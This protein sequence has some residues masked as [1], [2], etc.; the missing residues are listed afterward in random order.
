MKEKPAAHVVCTLAEGGYFNG[1]AALT[2]SLV[3]AGFKGNIVVGY[4]GGKP[5]WTRSLRVKDHASHVYE[6]ASGVDLRFVELA[7][8]WHLNNLK[9]HLI[10]RIFETHSDVDLIYYLDT[11]IVLKHAWETLVEWAREGVVLVLDIADSNMSPHHVYRRAWQKLSARRSLKCREVAGYVNGGCVGVN[12]AFAE[13][14][15][16]WWML[17]EELEHLGADM[18]KMKDLAGRLEFTRMDQDV[19]NATVMATETPIAL[20]GFEAMGLFPYS[21]LVMQHAI[22]HEKPWS[23]NYVLDALHGFPPDRT[24]LAYWEFV[25]G[26]IRPFTEFELKRKQMAIAIA[27]FIGFLHSRSY[28]D[29]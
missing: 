7:G 25:N 12:W 17:M 20:L 15:R 21:G 2:N 4:R 26:P 8:P 5:R 14:P 3:G 23:R 27:R 29:L 10:N 24:H 9:A 6:V 1:L 16:V 11:D 22:F 13:F 18:R 19:L 28:R